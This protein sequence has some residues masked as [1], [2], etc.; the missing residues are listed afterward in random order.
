MRT[1]WPEERYLIIRWLNLHSFE[2]KKIRAASIG[3]ADSYA[4]M[5]AKNERENPSSRLQMDLRK[6]QVDKLNGTE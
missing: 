2:K 3:W 1:L 6:S 4:R 5:G